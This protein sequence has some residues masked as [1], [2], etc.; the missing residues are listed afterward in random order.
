MNTYRTNHRMTYGMLAGLVF[1]VCMGLLQRPLV[2]MARADDQQGI[3]NSQTAMEPMQ[4]DIRMASK[5]IGM[6]VRGTGS[7]KLGKV[8][9]IVLTPGSTTIS[10]VALAHGGGLFGLGEKMFAVPWSAVSISPNGTSLTAPIGKKELD[11]SAGFAYSAWPDRGDARWS[12]K[13]YETGPGPAMSPESDVFKVRSVSQIT[14]LGIVN[15]Q[16]ASLGRIDDLGFDRMNGRVVYGIVSWAG[17]L[18]GPRHLAAV[19]WETVV[20]QSTPPAAGM[21]TDRKTLE[22]VAF[23]AND[24]PNLSDSAYLDKIYRTFGEEPYRQTYGYP[25]QEGRAEDAWLTGSQY[26]QRFNSS[27]IETD[28]GIVEAAGN[29]RPV[30]HSVS[31]LRLT[32]ATSE[33]QSLTVHVGPKSYIERKGFTVKEGD[34]VTVTGSRVEMGSRTIL[35]ASELTSGGTTIKLRDSYGSPLWT[36]SDVKN[37]FKIKA[38]TELPNMESEQ[39]P[40]GNDFE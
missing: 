38:S 30:N 18:S 9:D 6:E 27:T 33:G 4:M 16:G 17:L 24:R 5:L 34:S 19:P 26:S 13:A 11:E 21:D 15:K 3:S 8:R 37:E 22:S 12:A 32:I 10:Y 40:P 1:V 39:V 14:N 23:T 31:G 36:S 28:S 29:F 35:M 25:S 20:L 2:S 7:E